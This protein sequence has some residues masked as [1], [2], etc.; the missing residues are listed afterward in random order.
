LGYFAL[1]DTS[2]LKQEA[3]LHDVY[4]Y[5]V[6]EDGN[7]E[8]LGPRMLACHDALE[9]SRLDAVVAADVVPYTP[10]TSKAITILYFPIRP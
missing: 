10:A 6:V 8:E 2:V 7:Q 4:A 9:E 1:E 5:V 3:Q